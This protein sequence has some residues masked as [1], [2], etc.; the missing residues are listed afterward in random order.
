[1]TE[2]RNESDEE[3]INVDVIEALALET[4]RPIDEVKRV[5]E[6]EL[7]RLKSE[8]RVTDYVVLFASRR[9]RE[10]LARSTS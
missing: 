8:A 9:A 3:A 1:V 10:S 2:L 5:Y 6:D 7:A 4:S